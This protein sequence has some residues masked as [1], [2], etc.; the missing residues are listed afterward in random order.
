MYLLWKTVVRALDF[1]TNTI[2]CSLRPSG[3]AL[4][5]KSSLMYFIPL[6]W[7]VHATETLKGIEEDF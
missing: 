7:D 3:F 2:Q 6:Y 1:I 4:L 5:P